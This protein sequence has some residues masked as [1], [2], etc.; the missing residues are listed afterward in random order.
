MYWQKRFD[1]EDP[2]ANLEKLIKEIFE[3]NK[4]IYGYRRIQLT[5]KELGMKVNQKKIRR[6]VRKL[7]LKG[8][9]FTHKS[10]KY[11]SY[12]GTIGRIAKNL[13]HRRF[14]TSIPHQKLTIDTSEFKYYEPD[15]NG[16]PVIK[17][18]YLDPFLDM[19]NGEILSYRISKAP[20]A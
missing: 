12:K 2:N 9:K 5:L 1:R 11:N 10:R 7:G 18:L 6:I 8:M 17:K 13:I 16:K 20:N 4:G 19:Y 15:Q 3:E 14:Y